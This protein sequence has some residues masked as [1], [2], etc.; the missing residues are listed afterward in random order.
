MKKLLALLG[1][2]A[3]FF[4]GACSN[5][6][7][8]EPEDTKATESS[9]KIDDEDED[10]QESEELNVLSERIFANYLISVP[11]PTALPTD[12]NIDWNAVCEDLS[13]AGVLP[14]SDEVTY[15]LI[16]D[17]LL[18]EVR[19]NDADLGV[20]V[21][22]IKGFGDEFLDAFG[23]RAGFLNVLD[24][25]FDGSGLMI[26]IFGTGDLDALFDSVDER[27][28]DLVKTEACYDTAVAFDLG[29]FWEFSSHE[30]FD[31]EWSI[32]CR[33]LENISDVPVVDPSSLAEFAAGYEFPT[34]D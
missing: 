9:T 16:N 8:A 33:S 20:D 4:I 19:T 31:G 1:V 6:D 30:S 28:L 11:W 15:Q 26:E 34:R 12:D 17:E 7:T 5:D 2:T 24:E 27:E 32:V 3:L 14:A 29:E 10:T 23:N 21:S 13:I 18:C 25:E 22:D